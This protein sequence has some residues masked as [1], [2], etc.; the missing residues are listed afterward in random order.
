MENFYLHHVLHSLS[1]GL[2][3]DFEQNARILDLG[4]GGG[5]P[6]V[7]LAILFPETTF[8]L[9]DSI[10]K[11][12]RVIKEVSRSL[13]LTNVYGIHS[14]AENLDEEFDFVVCRAV[15]RLSKLEK[16]SRKLISRHQNH[17]I[18]NGLVCLKGGDLKEEIKEIGTK[19]Y[20][21]IALSDYYTERYFKEKYLV[22]L[23]M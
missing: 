18:P 6:G 19:P 20:E 15:A 7:P 21:R 22:Y 9:S 3:I 10:G 5:F 11:K 8:V 14:R 4:S 16:W 2:W 12:V 1:I 23:Q 17:A 13:E